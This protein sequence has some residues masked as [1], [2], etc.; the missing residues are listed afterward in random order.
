MFVCTHLNYII[1]TAIYSNTRPPW[2]QQRLKMHMLSLCTTHIIISLFAS[3][4]ECVC[5]VRR[6]NGK[7]NRICCT[8]AHI[9]IVNGS[10]SVSV[11]GCSELYTLF[12]W[13]ATR[14]CFRVMQTILQISSQNRDF[15]ARRSRKYEYAVKRHTHNKSYYIKVYTKPSPPPAQ[16]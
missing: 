6:L 3:M 2:E 8:Y 13:A 15:S 5:A 7:G 4:C 16:S 11:C 9:R 14:T 1:Q 12:C 10:E